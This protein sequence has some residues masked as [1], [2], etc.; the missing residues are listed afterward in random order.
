ME[1]LGKSDLVIEAVFENMALK[2]EVFQKL[3]KIAKS[4]AIIATNTSTLDVDD[5]AAVTKRPQDV[6]GLHF[7]SPANIMRLLEIVRAEKTAND[8]MATAMAIAKRIGKVGVQAGVCDGFVG[9]RM[10]AAYV[11]EV[12]AMTL[13]GAMPQEIDGALEGWGMAM[14]PLAVSDLAGL[15][16]GYRIRK[17]R[18]LTG[19]AAQFARVPDKIVEMGRHGQKTGAG[20]YKYDANRKRQVDPEI[21]AL[22]RAEAEALQIKQRHIPAEEIV[23][24]CLLRLANEGA[25]ILEEGIALRASDCDVMYLNGYGFPAWRGGPM[26]QADNMGLEEGGRA[27]QGLRGQVRRPLEDRPADRE[28]RGRRRHLRRPGRQEEVRRC[29][30]GAR[31]R[32]PAIPVLCGC[33]VAQTVPRGTRRT[34]DPGHKARDDS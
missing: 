18:K 30:P 33:A 13:E 6:V 7:F 19:E 25:K 26:W 31:P 21:E 1:D 5:I 22:I 12:Q 10:L 2:K 15:D 9:N 8:V 32:D 20:Y 17:E 34:M 23:E 4:G 16:V 24:R 28:A 14:G 3:D 11:G 29:H 27:H